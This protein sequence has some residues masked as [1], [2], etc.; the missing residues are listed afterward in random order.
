MLLQSGLQVNTGLIGTISFALFT[1]AA[2]MKTMT[3]AKLR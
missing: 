2:I 3:T 1:P